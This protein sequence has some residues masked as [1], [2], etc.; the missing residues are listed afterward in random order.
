MVILNAFD[1]R[2]EDWLSFKVPLEF[3]RSPS[4]YSISIR[5]GWEDRGI[6]NAWYQFEI[7][8]CR[9]SKHSGDFSVRRGILFSSYSATH[10]LC[11]ISM[12]VTECLRASVSS[13]VKNKLLM[14][15]CSLAMR[16]SWLMQEKSLKLSLASD[17]HLCGV[18]PPAMWETWVQ[19]LGW[20]DPLEKGKATHS[21]ILAWRILWMV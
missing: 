20:E 7:I 6:R 19:A 2:C 12:L 14:T 8:T 9:F 11:D 18:L 21:S 10:Q 15:G 1:T 4:S 17:T 5:L 16:I 3:W 13:Q